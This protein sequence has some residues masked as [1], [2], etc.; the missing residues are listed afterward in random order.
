MTIFGFAHTEFAKVF[1]IC[2]ETL[3]SSMIQF[4]T[5]ED[6][7]VR[8]RCYIVL[9]V[10]TLDGIKVNNLNSSTGTLIVIDALPI[11]QRLENIQI[12]DCEKDQ[13]EWKKIKPNFKP[14]IRALKRKPESL[15]IVVKKDATLKDMISIVANRSVLDKVLAVAKGIAPEKRNL[16][17]I[18]VAQFLSKKLSFK[19]FKIKAEQLN[20]GRL[21]DKMFIILQSII[22]KRLSLALQDHLKGAP[23][24]EVAKKYDVEASEIRFLATHLKVKTK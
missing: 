19:A 8:K 9:G 2:K 6:K 1:S 24:Q 3:E 5:K 7:V 14:L 4:L 21:S 10:A 13:V 15:K 18:Y 11:L 23:V 20:S 17:H 22:A 12:L 16:L